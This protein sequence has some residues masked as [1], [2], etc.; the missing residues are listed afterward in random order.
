M[1]MPLCTE[2]FC[3]IFIFLEIFSKSLI[4]IRFYT[5]NQSVFYKMLWFLNFYKENYNFTFEDFGSMIGL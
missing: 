4:L 1:L 5:R 2:N 3:K